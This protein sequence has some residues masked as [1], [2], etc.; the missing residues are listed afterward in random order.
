MDADSIL[1]HL[2]IDLVIIII[3]ARSLGWVAKRLN[4]PAVIGEIIAG[5]ILGPTVIGR[6]WPSVPGRLFPAAVPLAFF[7]DIGLIFFMFLVGLE[8]N[9]ELMRKEGRRALQISLSGIVA[10]F[11]LGIVLATQMTGV[12]N[13]GNFADNVTARP[14]TLTFALFIGASMC[15]TAF[16]VLARMLIE[17]GLYKQSFGTAALCAAAVDDAIAWILLASVVGLTRNGSASAAI[18]VFLKAALFVLFMFLVGTRLLSLLAKRYD[19]VGHLT[20]D[21]VAIILAGVLL[22]AFTT[23]YIGIHFVFGA[24]LFGAIMPKRSGMTRELTDKVEDFTVIVLLPIFFAVTGLGTNLFSLNSPALIGWLILILLVATIGKFAG[25]GLAARLTGSSRRDS[26]I[27]GALMNTRGLTELVILSIGRSLHVLSDRTFAMMV[28]MALVTTVMA[29]PI[30]NRLTSRDEQIR[31][32]VGEAPDV[33]IIAAA[34][35]LVAIG[36]PQNAPSLVDAAIRLTGRKRPAELLLVRLIPTP[37]APEF[38]TGLLEAESQ[39]EAAIESMRPLVE[40]AA[41][42]GVVARPISFLSNDVSPDLARIAR[43]QHC[44]TM[45]LGWHRASLPKHVIQAL[46]H[47][48]FTLAS[49]DVTVFVDPAGIGIRPEADRPVVIILGGRAQDEGAIRLGLRLAEDMQTSIKLVGY[50]GDQSDRALTVVSEQLAERADALRQQSGRWVVPVF[51][52]SDALNVAGGETAEGVVAV[53]PVGD[54]WHTEEDFGHPAA[55]LAELTACPMFVVRAADAMS[56]A[57][58]G[59]RRKGRTAR[60]TVPL[61]R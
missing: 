45:L 57:T 15:I 52:G 18:P 29:A 11:T 12:N 13:G 41:A 46:V 17:T 25:C 8:L 51:V 16:P 6:I 22:C 35:I 61:G 26:V 47:R 55:E 42:A 27:L 5:I 38:R 23:Q 14:H 34:R 33:A 10:P 21:M 43:D 53:V 24:F 3:A 1:L 36:N 9:P 31:D 2:I 48:I 50:V 7:A 49:C 59:K 44:D 37:R 4:Q 19:A 28:I 32:L 54:D 40:Q 20:V 60:E 58:N 56:G 30:V 39:I